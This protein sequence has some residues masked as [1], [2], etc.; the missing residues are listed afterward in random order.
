MDGPATE[1]RLPAHGR[2][3]SC[4]RAA[5]PGTG[6]RAQAAGRRQPSMAAGR[7]RTVRGASACVCELARRLPRQRRS[8]PPGNPLLERDHGS[9]LPP[10]AQGD[11]IHAR[12]HDRQ[13]TPGLPE[14]GEVL[15]GGWHL[16]SDGPRGAPVG[17]P[18]RRWTATAATRPRRGGR[19]GPRRAAKPRPRQMSGVKPTP[20]ILHLDPAAAP[21]DAGND[22]V[23]VAWATMAD[24]V[25]S[26]FRDSE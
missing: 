26:R 3:P 23:S 10:A 4:A 2:P 8:V 9:L 6:S 11:I 19:S 22:L 17:A 24:D 13:A 5:E 21:A 18:G 25:G 12:P 7:R 20:A 15:P 16:V 1:R 14:R